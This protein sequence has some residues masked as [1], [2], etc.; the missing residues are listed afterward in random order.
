MLRQGPP[1]DRRHAIGTQESPGEFA[2]WTIVMNSHRRA[3]PWFSHRNY[4]GSGLN[5][6]RLL[7]GNTLG[8]NQHMKTPNLRFSSR[9]G[10]KTGWHLISNSRYA[11]RG[12]QNIGL[13]RR[14]KWAGSG[15]WLRSRPTAAVR[16]K[17]PVARVE[18]MSTFVTFLSTRALPRSELAFKVADSRPNRRSDV[19]LHFI[20]QDFGLRR[21]ATTQTTQ[22]INGPCPEK[23]TRSSQQRFQP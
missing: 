3:M 4:P 10:R 13:G 5:I 21:A 18:P 9:P 8:Q 2:S 23:R 1:E 12:D 15:R 6:A 20:Q 16:T 17:L 7:S 19:C 22:G 14:Q 11:G